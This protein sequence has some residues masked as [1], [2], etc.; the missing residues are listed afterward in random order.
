[1]VLEGA[2]SRRGVP[3]AWLVPISSSYR[4]GTSTE[5]LPDPSKDGQLAPHWCIFLAPSRETVASLLLS[6]RRPAEMTASWFECSWVQVRRMVH[7]LHDAMM[8]F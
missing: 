8:L 1:M 2:L 7:N 3:V 4:P 6:I 5:T